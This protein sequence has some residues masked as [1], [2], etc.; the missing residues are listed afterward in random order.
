[1]G[2]SRFKLVC[3][4]RT[5]MDLSRTVCA[6]KEQDTA[7]RIRL[8]YTLNLMNTRT[9]CT[10][11]LLHFSA[12][13]ETQLNTPAS[14]QFQISPTLHLDNLTHW[15]FYS[16][17]RHSKLDIPTSRATRGSSVGSSATYINHCNKGI[18]VGGWKNKYIL[19]TRQ[20]MELIKKTGANLED[21]DNVSQVALPF[22]SLLKQRQGVKNKELLYHSVGCTLLELEN[23]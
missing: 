1:M 12:F 18:L 20:E 3:S 11:S 4:S 10:V 5:D 15:K 8:H 9:T 21:D 6:L 22:K 2:C 19:L 17:S 7:T 23:G 13:G 16:K 14:Y